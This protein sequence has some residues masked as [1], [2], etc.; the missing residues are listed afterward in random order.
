MTRATQLQLGCLQTMASLAVY[1]P[2]AGAVYRS[3]RPVLES[4]ELGATSL[5]L[6]VQYSLAFSHRG[7]ESLES[8]PCVALH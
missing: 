1:A 8:I 2:G 7:L 4:H 5:R 6:L 3:L